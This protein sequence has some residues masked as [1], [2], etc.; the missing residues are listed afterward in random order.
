MAVVTEEAAVAMAGV[1]AKMVKIMTTSIV[2][3]RK[4]AAEAVKA[5]AVVGSSAS[6]L[7]TAVV[8]SFKTAENSKVGVLVFPNV[9]RLLCLLSA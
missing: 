7:S 5:V 9:C 6:H 4:V 8:R 2:M 1:A 3:A